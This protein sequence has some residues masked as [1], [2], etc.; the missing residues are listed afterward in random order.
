MHVRV[1]QRSTRSASLVY[2]GTFAEGQFKTEHQKHLYQQSTY[3]V[4]MLQAK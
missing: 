3:F 1:R 4:Y 2:F